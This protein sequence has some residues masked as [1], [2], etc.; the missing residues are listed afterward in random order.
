MINA[1][2]SVCVC[3]R[4]DRFFLVFVLLLFSRISLSLW[5]VCVL[6]VWVVVK[7]NLGE[8]KRTYSHEVDGLTRARRGEGGGKHHEP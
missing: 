2:A 8:Y 5:V 1:R 4:L 6:G 7:N 3:V